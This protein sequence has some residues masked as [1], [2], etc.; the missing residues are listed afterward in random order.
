MRFPEPIERE[1]LRALGAYL[2]V[3]QVSELPRSIRRFRTFRP[4][5]LRPHLDKLMAA[6]SEDE[7]LRADILEWLEEAKPRLTAEEGRVL[8]VVAEQAE[9]WEEQLAGEAVPGPG[10][11]ASEPGDVAARPGAPELDHKAE[12][13]RLR[14][15]L[16]AAAREHGSS[17]AALTRQVAE[18][19]VRA[20]GAESAAGAATAAAQAAKQAQERG[21]RRLQ[22]A[23]DK[24]VAER[25][26]ALSEAKALRREVKREARRADVAEKAL[27]AARA[28]RNAGARA[29]AEAGREDG[30]AARRRLRR[31]LP[32]PPG[33]LEEDPATLS[34]WLGEPGVRLLVDGYNVAKQE[35]AFK[36][37]QGEDQRAR[38]LDEVDRLVRR[39]GAP[40][41]VVFD[42]DEVAP[43]T[44][45]RRRGLA[46]VEFSRPP[47]DGDSHLVALLASWPP[48]PVV[49]ATSDKG[50]QERCRELGA[51][52]A[53][54]EQLLAAVR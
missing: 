20:E 42:G 47:E 10:A 24:A 54:S 50:L 8:R 48:A 3:A 2:R 39:H 12:V 29:G 37:L 49:V 28:E 46:K 26:R 18:M 5:A 44:P 27:T 15:Q 14:A 17:V 25:D 53:T 38:T 31:P 30:A 22:R 40:A 43:G 52:I 11:P 6:V 7:D 1:L 36:A 45:R 9:G 13:R 51:T 4:A 34:R 32:V 19:Q 35:S 23:A 16:R 33:L 41:T 21:L